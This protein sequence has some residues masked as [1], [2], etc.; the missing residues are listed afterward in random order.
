MIKVMT[1]FIVQSANKL[2]VLPQQSICPWRDKTLKR[3]RKTL[4]RGATWDAERKHL[5]VRGLCRSH[6]EVSSVF[7]QTETTANPGVAL[8]RH[9]QIE[10]QTQTPFEHSLAELTKLRKHF[11]LDTSTSTLHLNGN[12]CECVCEREGWEA[13][14]MDLFEG[15][16]AYT[17]SHKKNTNAHRHNRDKDTIKWPSRVD[18]FSTVRQTLQFIFKRRRTHMPN[19]CNV[20]VALNLL[21][22]ILCVR[23]SVT[24]AMACVQSCCASEVSA[25]NTSTLWERRYNSKVNTDL[26]EVWKQHN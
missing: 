17:H 26:R 21:R 16:I 1:L 11:S 18:A 20:E 5:K 2:T 8:N 25:P 22:V 7:C 23:V 10:V 19:P 24:L 13:S 14:E 15:V 12:T 3:K 4:D 6:K 9:I